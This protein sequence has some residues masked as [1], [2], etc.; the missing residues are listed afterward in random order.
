MESLLQDLRFTFRQLWNNKGFAV[1]AIVS[2]ALGIGATTAVFSVVYG[3]LIDPYPYRDADRM[4]HVQMLDTA[5][6]EAGLVV[7]TGPEHQEL[8]QAKCVDDSFQQR[9]IPATITG[10]QLPA[11]VQM[12]EYTP[13]LFTYMGVPPLRGRFFTAA[14]APEGKPEPVAVLSYLFWK[15]QFG[16]NPNVLGSTIELD[17]KPYTVIGIAPPRFTWG[18]TEV[19]VPM[20][21]SA[22][23]HDY[24]NDFI[25]LK[26]GVTR[27]AAAA[28]LEP[29]FRRFIE[30]DPRS[31]A[32]VSHIKVV[33]L[34]EQILGRF[35]GTIL[36]LF[37]AV[38]LLLV[39]GCANVSILLMAR[40]AARVH[41]LAVRSSIGA[42]R[43]R[44]VRQ[45]LT[46][47]LLLSITGAVLGVLAAY[48]GVALIAA[49]LPAFSFPHEAAIHV[50]GYVLAFTGMVALLTGILFGMSPALRLS[51]PQLGQLIQ[52]G[53]MRHSGSASS[54]RTHR[55]LIASQVAL[56]ILL[57]A[58]A[59]AAIR[60]FLAQY[61]IPL[62]YEP[63]NVT[64]L[65]LTL[66]KGSYPKWQERV[67]KV[68]AVRETIA[69]TPGVADAAGTVTWFPPFQGYTNKIEIESRQN[70]TGLQSQLA[71]V[72]PHLFSTLRIPL[73]NGRNFTDAE[74]LR[75]AHVALVN[76]TFV[77]KFLPD[78]DPIG[79]HVRTSGLKFESPVLVFADNNDD[80]FEIVGVVAD[81]RNNGTERTIEPALFVPESMVVPPQ[82]SLMLRTPLTSDEVVHNVQVK[83]RSYDPELA[84]IDHHPLTWF[85]DTVIWGRERFVAWVFV[86][87]SG[88]ALVLAAMGLY[89]VISYTVT[90]RNQEMGIRMALGAQ[91]VDIV[92][93]VVMSAAATV[94]AG[95]LVGMVLSVALNRVIVHWVDA[96][97]RD[98]L[99][100]AAVAAI[101][102]VIALIA[103]A[104]PARRAAGLDPMKALRTE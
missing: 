83:L 95:I 61:K 16:A 26:P 39:I 41:E 80:W 29:L 43:G 5:G 87:F 27:E 21:P 35:A 103:C 14:D 100:L 51:R 60:G 49:A 101:L 25:K 47:S 94:G 32:P 66:P 54:R 74:N 48:K 23:P 7:T 63:E 24:Y 19:Y 75:A 42:S 73:L 84:T 53:G 56:T 36:L 65:N 71:L 13:N 33:T 9:N 38:A 20:V 50:N 31:F 22:D 69:S 40:G 93:L 102:V 6:R 98:P 82:I 28:E 44:I 17:R 45:L 30:R 34:N 88:L 11:A 81:A 104:L 55:L 76:Q 2:L 91:R 77:K 12:G 99:M 57:L 67:N 3:L 59:G 92:R 79:Q 15:R 70:V 72:N 52:S 37:A 64:S 85:L 97:S 46:E 58:V 8:L 86:V 96:G 62:G 18:D 78:V 1:T 4:I 10:N 89:S 68:E 90:Q